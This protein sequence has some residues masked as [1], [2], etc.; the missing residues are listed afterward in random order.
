M[1][2]LLL[3]TGCELRRYICVIHEDVNIEQTEIG[4]VIPAGNIKI[5]FGISKNENICELVERQNEFLE[6]EANETEER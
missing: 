1:L 3:T 6:D 2:M 5:A 4:W